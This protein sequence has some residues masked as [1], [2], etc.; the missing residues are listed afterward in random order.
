[1]CDISYTYKHSPSLFLHCLKAIEKSWEFCRPLYIHSSKIVI[2]H[3]NINWKLSIFDYAKIW[4]IIIQFSSIVAVCRIQNIWFPWIQWI[5][6]SIIQN[7]S[8]VLVL[9]QLNATWT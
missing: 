2:S 3:L 9:F 4:Y 1:M 8:N 5:L 6:L 7:V